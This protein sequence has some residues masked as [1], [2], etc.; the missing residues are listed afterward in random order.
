MKN[1]KYLVIGALVALSLSSCDKDTE[2]LTYI[3]D[4][5]NLQLLGD[6]FMI[7]PVGSEFV[8][9]GCTGTLY[10]KNTGNT[11]DVSDKIIVEGDVNTSK[12]GFYYI[13]YTAA[14]SDGFLYNLKR[15]VCVCDPS[16]TIDM[17]GTYDTDMDLSMRGTHSFFEYAASYGYTTEC[18]G[19]TFEEL[20]PGFYKVSDIMGGWY[21]QLRG[22]NQ[23]YPQYPG[24]GCMTGY[25]SL[26]NDGNVNLI[27][28]YIDAW[29]DGLDYLKNGKFDPETG[30][31]TYSL[32]YGGS[33]LLDIVLKKAQQ[34]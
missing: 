27:S 7:V 28:S 1:I 21:D 3:T 8:D 29:G 32:S 19:I 14:S 30:T 22:F 15:T 18:T 31:I 5:V 25:V 6:E 33:V 16:V 34:Q 9:P 24:I 20:A 17:S 13:T 12:M 26:D 10:D 4:H 2:G 23:I 11:V